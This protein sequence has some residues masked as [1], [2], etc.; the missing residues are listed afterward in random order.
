MDTNLT[1]HYLATETE[2][3]RLPEQAA[4]G[5]LIEQ[6]VAAQQTSVG[7]TVVRRWIGGLMIVAGQRVQGL[8]EPTV[9]MLDP[10]HAH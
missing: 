8:P 5:W 6:A 2:R 9:T 10:T 7:P 4:R 3:A 1:A